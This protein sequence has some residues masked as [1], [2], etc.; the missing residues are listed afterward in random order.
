MEIQREFERRSQVELSFWLYGY[1]PDSL[2]G[3]LRSS[4]FSVACWL[5]HTGL[6]TERIRD[7]RG[8]ALEE[9]V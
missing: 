5:L 7:L 3:E 9:Q 4:V 6:L 8:E 2:E 1:F